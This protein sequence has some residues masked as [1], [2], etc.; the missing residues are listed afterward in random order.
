MEEQTGILVGLILAA[1]LKYGA[2]WW[3]RRRRNHLFEQ[4]GKVSKIFIY[5]VKSCKGVQLTE[6]TCTIYG[7]ENNGVHDR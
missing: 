4:I 3:M 5:P 6:G 2:S 7:I 1:T